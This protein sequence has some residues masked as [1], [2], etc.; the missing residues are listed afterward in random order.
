[1]I[2]IAI[3]MGWHTSVFLIFLYSTYANVIGDIDA[4]EA[5]GDNNQ[6]GCGCR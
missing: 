1:M 5:A 6:G 2:P 4:Y 3:W